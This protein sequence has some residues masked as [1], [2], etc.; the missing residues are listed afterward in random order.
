[1]TPVIIASL[2]DQVWNVLIK[3][4]EKRFLL[5]KIVVIGGGTVGLDIAQ[6]FAAAAMTLWSRD[7]KD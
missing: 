1:M 6:V 5:K 7:I 3:P 4:I 2:S